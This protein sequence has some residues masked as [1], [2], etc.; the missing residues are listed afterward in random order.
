M[1]ALR[2]VF[3]SLELRVARTYLQSG[4]VVFKTA[5]RDFARLRKR[6]ESGIEANFGFRPDV[7]LRTPA[8][9]RAVIA[10]NPFAARAD[11]EPSKLLVSF[12][13][14][15]P[16]PDVLDKLLSI[17]SGPDELRPDGR[18]LFIYFPNGM[19]RPKLSPALLERMLKTPSTGRNWNTVRGLLQIA[20]T[21][22][23][24]E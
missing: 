5:A 1:D 22:E 21:L 20:E 9:L 13:S 4:N 11:V 7:I 14:S 18:E 10:K 16:S 8:E 19:G 6:I 12:L 17:Q 24:A 3:E 15:E 23:A 2:A